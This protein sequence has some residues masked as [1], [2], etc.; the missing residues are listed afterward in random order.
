MPPPPAFHMLL[1][2]VYAPRVSLPNADDVVNDGSAQAP[3]PEEVG[4]GVAGA[5]ADA[6][7]VGAGLDEEGEADGDVPGE[8][9]D[10]DDGDGDACDRDEPDADEPDADEPDADAD[11][12][13]DADG[14]D[15]PAVVAAPVAVEGPVG[16]A[17]CPIM[18][19]CFPLAAACLG[20]YAWAGF[21]SAAGAARVV[22]APSAVPGREAEVTTCAF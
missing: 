6:D 4:G 12:D 7:A 9:S 20:T 13:A 19:A 15:C 17:V 8:E 3:L 1:E 18:A 14:A 2:T 5:D 11:R 16:A 10:G 22:A 21:P